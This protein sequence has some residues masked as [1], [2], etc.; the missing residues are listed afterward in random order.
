[1]MLSISCQIFISLVYE[2]SHCAFLTLTLR[3]ICV[4]GC[5]GYQRWTA[6]TLVGISGLLLGHLI[7]A[8]HYLIIYWLFGRFDT[9]P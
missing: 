2:E 6:L 5:Q 1:M 7:I 8:A 3:G 4:Y 9:Q